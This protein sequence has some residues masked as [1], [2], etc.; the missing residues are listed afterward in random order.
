M[1]R[2]PNPC[3]SMITTVPRLSLQSPG[4]VMRASVS[5]AIACK[6]LNL[7]KSPAASKIA[8]IFQAPTRSTSTGRPCRSHPRKS[9]N[10]TDRRARSELR[11]KSLH[12]LSSILLS[13]RHVFVATSLWCAFVTSNDSARK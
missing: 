13:R 4:L 10:S 9:Y 5:T 1:W 2:M 12:I 3:K 8:S 11:H 7:S 6:I